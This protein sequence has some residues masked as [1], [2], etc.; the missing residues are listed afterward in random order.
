MVNIRTALTSEDNCGLLIENITGYRA[1]DNPTGF[2]TSR[3]GTTPKDYFIEDV[4]LFTFLVKNNYDGTFKNIVLPGNTGKTVIYDID[5]SYESA[6]EHYNVTQHASFTEDGYY[7]IYQLAIPKEST[8][9]NSPLTS[10]NVYTYFVKSDLTV[11]LRY[12]NVDTL[13]DLY[14]VSVSCETDWGNSNIIMLRSNLV[15]K[16]FLEGCLNAILEIFAKNYTDPLC[17]KDNI[18]FKQI[19]DKRDL[20]FAVTNT[21]QYYVEL[22]Q[23]YK[24][25]KLIYDVTFCN[26]CR[27]YIAQNPNLN[28]NCH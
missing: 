25:A 9:T 24:A 11:W 22:G 23:Y 28:C 7:S 5:E 19:K 14:S 6:M 21:I 17:D 15:S 18:L 3:I 20:L 16:C 8:L 10:V 2:L 12:G 13:V 1:T 26:I 4:Y 27:D